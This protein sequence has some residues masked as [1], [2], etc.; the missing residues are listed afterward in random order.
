M[1]IYGVWLL[2][3]VEFFV[4]SNEVAL[5]LHS[6]LS[7]SIWFVIVLVGAFTLSLVE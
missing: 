7:F 5:L 1:G 6:S 2:I 4:T 3:Y